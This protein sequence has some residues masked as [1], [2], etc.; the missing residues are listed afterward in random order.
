[1]NSEVFAPNRIAVVSDTHGHLNPAL[2]EDLKN[3]DLII[4]AGDLDGPEVLNTLKILAPVLAVRG[5][6]DRGGWAEDIPVMEVT[7]ING[8]LFYMIHDLARMDLEPESM[9]IRFVIS[10]HTHRP[11]V[12][13]KGNVIYLNP[14]SASLPRGGFPPTYALIHIR[15]NRLNVEIKDI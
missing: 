2:L 14:G 8:M 5:N 7:P 4:H 3:A 15:E 11:L 12:E 1:M 9:G 6:M 10:G 13:E